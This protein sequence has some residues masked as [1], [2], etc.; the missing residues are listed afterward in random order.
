VGINYKLGKEMRRNFDEISS[1]IL[2]LF[3]INI[4]NFLALK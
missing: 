4:I 1:L 2:T 3:L